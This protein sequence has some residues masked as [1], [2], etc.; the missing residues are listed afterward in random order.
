MAT[1]IDMAE[2]LRASGKRLKR[3]LL[4]AVVTA[5]EYLRQSISDPGA[6][7]SPAFTP[8]GPLTAMPGIAVS[9]AELDALVR[10]LLGA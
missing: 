5:E 7:T 2:K 6:F 4:F 8:M 1:L 9:P 3:S 10:Y